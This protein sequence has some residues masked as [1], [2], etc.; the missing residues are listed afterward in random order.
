ML[1]RHRFLRALKGCSF[2]SVFNPYTDHCAA[3]D[4]Q[5][6]PKIRERNLLTL[7]EAMDGSVGSIWFGRDLGYLGGRRT[8][9][10]L[11]DEAHL[12]DVEIVYGAVGLARATKGA[13]VAE[14]TATT[15]WQV[16]RQL[17]NPP[18][19]WNIFPFHPHAIDVQQMN[20]CHTRK[21]RRACSDVLNLLLEWAPNAKLVAIG[22]DAA[23]GLREAGLEHVLIR[24][25]SYG[26]T[27]DFIAGMSDF[28]GAPLSPPSSVSQ[29]ALF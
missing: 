12:K 11:T 2:P 9:L 16:L 3:F 7:M 10:A 6:A 19:L 20:R 15:S 29:P 18:F 22:N 24:H 17:P 21:E 13:P 25:P 1:V 8:G 4:V 5:A 23:L 28:Y 27:A 26:G 14:R